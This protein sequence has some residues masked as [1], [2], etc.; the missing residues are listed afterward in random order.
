MSFK[1]TTVKGFRTVRFDADVDSGEAYDWT[2]CSDK[3][4]DGDVLIVPSEGIV[5]FLYRA[6]PVAIKGQG[7]FDGPIKDRAVFL[8]DEPGYEA[9]LIHCESLPVPRKPRARSYV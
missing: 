2:Q 9:V 1:I 6:W 5:G 3:I 4:K 7:H 8:A